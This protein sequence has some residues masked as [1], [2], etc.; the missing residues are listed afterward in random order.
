[1]LRALAGTILLSGLAACGSDS[2]GSSSG[3]DAALPPVWSSDVTVSSCD[4]FATIG[5]GSYVISSNYWNK[6]T[7]PGTQCIEMNSS[8]GAF[9]VT[10]GPAPCGNNVASYPNVL[11]GCSYGNCSPATVLP[12]PVT[13]VSSL[14][15]NWDFSVGGSPGDAWN[16]SYDIWFCP[17]DNCGASGFPKGL[18]LM[19]W[20]DYSNAHGWRTN[21]G[22]KNL[23]GRN[24]DVWV[25]D[26]LVG[27]A[28]DSWTYLDYILKPPLV[29]SVTNLDLS[30][31]IQDALARGYIKSNWYL[32]AVQAGMEVRKGGIPFTSNSFSVTINGT[33]PSAI[34]TAS[35]GP[36]C[37]GGA[38][39]A[40]GQLAISGTYITAGSLHGYGG[41]W[42]AVDP[43]SA[44]TIC[45]SPVCTAGQTGAAGTCSPPLGSS[46]LCAA[47]VVSADP[48]YHATAGLGF[49]LNQDQLATGGAV[50]V[51][52]SVSDVDSSVSDIDGSIS[53]LDGGISDGGA[54]AAIGAITIP[55]SVTV[56]ISRP[57]K[58]NGN[59]NLRVQLTDVDGNLFCYGGPL[60][61]AILIGQF[62]TQC[63]NN[64]GTFATPSTRFTRLDI[65]VPSSATTDMSFGYCLTNV[66]I[67]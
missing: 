53:D 61:N 17:D 65:I 67:Q 59:A 50:D 30:A 19:I 12:L 13:Q 5:V 7:C 58:L 6:D 22:S 43:T 32:Y 64:K 25:A 18:E 36:S 15:S 35:Q 48:S 57:D 31:F 3:V 45:A 21:L 56:S 52:G 16:V 4:D 63:W 14:T 60:N 42:T 34:P 23:S 49:E 38:P 1:M 10:E 55:S 24:W 8:T 11:Y 20:L 41:A 29:T 54:I 39:T 46:A 47:G 9:S 27:G 28:T 26:M 2:G 40:D 37:D 51:D 33:T 62:N 44:A 66:V